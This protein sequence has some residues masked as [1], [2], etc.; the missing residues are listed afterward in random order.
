[1]QAGMS[2]GLDQGKK[3]EVALHIPIVDTAG[4]VSSFFMVVHGG[5]T[6]EV[7]EEDLDEPP[8]RGSRMVL[9]TIRG[10]CSTREQKRSTP[11]EFRRHMGGPKSIQRTALGTA[12]G[13]V[14]KR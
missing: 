2:F 11:L 3:N 13:R 14:N 6:E 8:K 7:A 9:F 12:A 10:A 4:S 5:F 1:M